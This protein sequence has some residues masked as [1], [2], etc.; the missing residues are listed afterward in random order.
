MAMT[1]EEAQQSIDQLVQ[2]EGAL[3]ALVTQLQARATAS[4]EEHKQIH[5]QL[6]RTQGSSHKQTQGEERGN[7]G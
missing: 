7:P 6:V 5:A 1:L 4:N 3:H 2:Q